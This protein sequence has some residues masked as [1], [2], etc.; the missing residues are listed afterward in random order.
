MGTGLGDVEEPVPR[1]GQR[2]RLSTWVRRGGD[3]L[4]L[5]LLL[6]LLLML[7]RSWQRLFPSARGSQCKATHALGGKHNL[8]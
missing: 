6:L 4:L 5:L 2:Q 1:T 8:G 7:L 3:K